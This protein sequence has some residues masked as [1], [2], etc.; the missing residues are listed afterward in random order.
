MKKTIV[1]IKENIY[2][3]IDIQRQAATASARDLQQY[4]ATAHY[5]HAGG[6]DAP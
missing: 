4:V 2:K 1:I 6:Q 5:L 3:N